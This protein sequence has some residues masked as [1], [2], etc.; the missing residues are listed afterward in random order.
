MAR[1]WG[2]SREGRGVQAGR[3]MRVTCV[4]STGCREVHLWSQLLRVRKEMSQA[5]TTRMR[6][7]D[8]YSSD[9]GRGKL[10]SAGKLNSS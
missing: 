3:E 9:L 10:V 1:D 7:L 5:G 8:V 2:D 4:Q 6:D